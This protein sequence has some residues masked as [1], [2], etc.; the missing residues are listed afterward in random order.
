MN[1]N[2]W[3]RSRVAGA[4]G[5]IVICIGT[6][7]AAILR[8]STAQESEMNLV[9]LQGRWTLESIDG[10]IVETSRDVFFELRGST[11][12]GFDG[13]N[14][15]GGPLDSPTRIRASQRSCGDDYVA[16]PLDLS[17]PLAQLR[18][19]HVKND[20]LILTLPGDQGTAVLRHSALD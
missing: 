3:E 5:V 16:L 10:K 7:F 4:F 11:I 19:A 2:L 9:N 8:I 17:N 14:S 1:M 18:A 15:F 6:V 20:R 13:C 12:T